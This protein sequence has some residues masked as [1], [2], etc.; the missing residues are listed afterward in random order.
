M[1]TFL[2]EYI[3]IMI[4]I[5]NTDNLGNLDIGPA[6]HEADGCWDDSIQS[7]A[8]SIKSKLRNL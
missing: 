4:H 5:K 3:D 6:V 7:D 2:H 1:T 8:W